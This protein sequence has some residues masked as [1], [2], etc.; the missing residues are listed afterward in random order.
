[1][2][3]LITSA[4]RHLYK[5]VLAAMFRARTRYFV[6][7]RG[8]SNLSVEG[9]QELDAYDT[10][11]ALYLVA[12]DEQGDIAVSCRLLPADRG[13]VL[14]DHFAHLVSDG[15]VTGP[16]IYEL[17]RYFTKPGL[18]GRECFPIKAAM[19]LAVVEAMVEREARRLV[20]FTDLHLL[21][22]MRYTGWRA[23]PIG[24]PADYDEGTAAAFEIACR[25][26]DLEDMREALEI[27]GRQLF[28]APAWLPSGADI[29]AIADA[30]D[31]ILNFPSAVRQPAL[32]AVSKAVRSWRPQGELGP[33]FAR[34]GERE[35]A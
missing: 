21:S 3:H 24:L 30:T 19:N 11:E 7:E 34:L 29:R 16:G 17:S 33:L 1:M 23:R 8:W 32:D 5:D 35:A 13:C 22:L 31:L 20:G 28:E 12:L 6:N 14:A 10:D 15:P 9:G 4:N 27:P 25:P 18:R 26:A 2:I